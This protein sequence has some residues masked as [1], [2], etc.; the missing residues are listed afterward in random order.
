MS[1][2]WRSR[3]RWAV[4]N[5]ACADCSIHD[6]PVLLARGADDVHRFKPTQ[7]GHIAGESY[8]I[9]VG[10][11]SCSHQYAVT[12]YSRSFEHNKGVPGIF[13]KYD[14]EALALT[15]RERTTSFYQFLIRLVGVIGAYP[16]SRLG[17]GPMQTVADSR[18]SVDC[19]GLWSAGIQSSP[20]GSVQRWE[21]GERVHP[22]CDPWQFSGTG[23]REQY[24]LFPRVESHVPRGELCVG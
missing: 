1:G 20:K 13:F 3:P 5:W 24:E 14:L 11:A 12:D 15:I 6:I 21:V 7:T 17:R 19:S 2:S 18:R 16:K 8:P 9:E 23:I 22:L 10:G 4:F